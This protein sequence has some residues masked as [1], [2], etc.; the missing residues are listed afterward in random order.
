MPVA[1]LRLCGPYAREV[2]PFAGFPARLRAIVEGYTAYLSG[3]VE[4]DG[5]L[6]A[7]VDEDEVRR[8]ARE[9]RD[10][11]LRNVVVVG[12]YSPIDTRYG[13]EEQVKR[14]LIEE[15]GAGA[16]VTL[17]RQVAQIGFLERENASILNAA[18]LPLARKTIGEFR[19]AFRDLDLDVPL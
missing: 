8:V 17:S 4:I 6:I 5:R 16:N 18:I 9:L 15:L 1:V 19:H 7:R 13:Q 12:V 11:G 14:I 10:E 3:G 2:P